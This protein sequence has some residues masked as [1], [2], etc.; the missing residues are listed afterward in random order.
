MPMLICFLLSVFSIYKLELK[1]I[2][3][4][5]CVIGVVIYMLECLQDLKP[6][7]L[8]KLLSKVM[9]KEESEEEDENENEAWFLSIMVLS[10]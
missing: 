6:P 5:V 10:F 3:P 1:V 4:R 8:L 2:L 7:L 9:E